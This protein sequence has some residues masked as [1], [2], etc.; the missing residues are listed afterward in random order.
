MSRG[1]LCCLAIVIS[2]LVVQSALG[3]SGG[4]GTSGDPYQ[5]ATKA[6][7]EQLA[8]TT[9]DYNKAFI[10]TAD[11]DLSGT[12]YTTAPIAPDM[13]DGTN[14][15]P[16]GYRFNG[17]F[18]GNGHRITGLTIAG[19]ARGCSCLGLIGAMDPYGTI[20]RLTIE[21][22]RI[23][24]SAYSGRV[25]ACVGWTHG[26][27]IEDCDSSGII[28]G[29]SSTGG[30]VGSF[31]SGTMKRCR[32][33]VNIDSSDGYTGGLVG[34]NY[35][36]TIAQCYAAGN[37]S[38]KMYVGGLIGANQAAVT[39]SYAL[40]AVTGVGEFS[41]AGGL[42]GLNT[43]AITRCYSTGSVTG[44]EAGGL[45][46]NISTTGSTTS[47]SF[48]DTQTS[49]LLTSPA[50]A[51]RTRL[52]MQDAGVFLAAGWDF[53]GESANGTND[54]WQMA[55]GDYPRLAAWPA[56]GETVDEPVFSVQGG[57]HPTAQNV[58]IICATPGAT[59]H[60]TTSGINPTES[61]AAISSGAT[62]LID[63][64]ITL[65]A[66]A[67]K[68]GMTA[69]GVATATYFIG[70]SY[71]GG[72]GTSADPYRISSKAD[73]LALAVMPA[74]YA[75]YFILTTD[76][77][78]TEEVFT[79]AV[80]AA[81]S[82]SSNGV[83]D[84][85]A[86]TGT[87]DGSGHAISNMVID[88]GES[89][90]DFLGL[91][92]SIGQTGKVMNLASENATIEAAASAN[93]GALVGLNKGTLQY[94]RSSGTING[95][96]CVGGLAG[97][98]N[99]GTMTRC[100]SS[101]AVSAAGSIAGGLIGS[102]D[103]PGTIV[104]SWATGNV[105][106]SSIAGGLAG[107]DTG[108]LGRCYATGSVNA[109]LYA[110]GLI[111]SLSGICKNCYATGSVTG[112]D[113]L[114]GL[115]GFI[116][117]CTLGMC[118]S[119]GRV[120]TASHCGGM[121]GGV[122]GTIT[123]SS[124]L[125]WDTQTSGRSSDWFGGG[126]TTAQM[127]T[128]STF[129]SAY[130]DFVGETTNGSNDYWYMPAG[131]YPM[132]AFQGIVATPVLT[133][134]TGTYNNRMN[135]TVTCDTTG[136][137]IHYTISGIDPTEADPVITSGTNILVERNL[138]IKVRAWNGSM[139]PS[140]V[141]TGTYTIVAGNSYSGG[142]GISVDP[143]VIAGKAD[144]LALAAAPGDY[145]RC[146]IMTADIDLAG[147]TYSTALIAPDTAPGT[148]DYQGTAFTGT[149]NGN[150]HSITALTVNDGG[151]GNDFLGLFGQVGT[152]G[153]VKSLAMVN[154][155]I[156]GSSGSG[157][158]GACAASTNS[159]SLEDCSSTGTISGGTRV[160]GLVGRNS[161]GTLTRCW[162]TANASAL[163]DYA[164]GLAAVNATGS[165]VSQCYATGNVSTPNCAGGLAGYNG[166]TIGN[167][168][169]TGTV[170]GTGYTGGLV[171]SSPG[172][173]AR[174][175][176][177]GYVTGT[178]NVGGLVGSGASTTNSF[179]D[180]QTSGKSTSSGGTG[181]TTAQM[182]TITVFIA[183]GWDFAGET[184]NGS[185]DYW[186]MQT[187][188]YPLLS[189]NIAVSD[190]VAAPVSS[191]NGGT[192]DTQQT[193]AIFCATA[194][195]AIHYTTN[196][197]DPVESDP[198]I[199]SGASVLVDHSMTL[200]A[201]AWKAGLLPSSVMT[202][203]YGIRVAIPSFNPAGGTY[204]TEQN[205][206]ISCTATDVTIHYTT[207]GLEPTESDPIVASGSSV[208]VDHGLTLKARAWKTDFAASSVKSG[209][210]VLV[211]S[212][213]VLSVPAG[214]YNTPQDVAV[215][216][217]AAGAVI[218]YTIDGN[219][220]NET[221]PIIASGDSLAIGQ[222][223]V[224]KVRAWKPGFV[225]SDIV[226]ARYNFYSGGAGVPADPFRIA[227]K[228]DLLTLAAMTGDYGK[229]FIMTSDIDL[230]GNVFA[231]AVIAPD[232]GGGTN[233]FVGTQW[234]GTFDGNGHTIS[235]L[236]ITG[237][238]STH[239]FLGLFGC[240]NSA[241]II[242][243]LVLE[244]VSISSTITGSLCGALVGENAGSI[245]NCHSGGTI[246]GYMV[247][248]GLVGSNNFGS[249]TRCYSTVAVSATGVLIGGLVGT[250]YGNISLSYATG[251]VSGSV[252]VGGL[253][254]GNGLGGVISDCYAT[255]NV[256]ATDT[257]AG[258]LI[259]VQEDGTVTRCYSAGHVTATSFAGGMIGNRTGA[260]I[261]GCFWDVQTS[262]QS[263]SPGGTGKTTLLMKTLSTYTAAGWD[264]A[265]ETANG[266]NDYWLMPVGSYPV[267]KLDPFAAAFTVV[268]ERRIGRT[269]FEYD[270]RVT[271]TN[272]GSESLN[273]SGFELT[274]VPA[275]VTIIDAST[276]GFGTI[277][278]GGSAAS[279]DT[280]T[281]RVD[282]SQLINSSQ[283]AWQITYEAAAGVQMMAT[284]NS[285][286]EL[287][288][289]VQGDVNADG[290]VDSADLTSLADQW[291]S[292][293]SS[294]G[295]VNFADFAALAANWPQEA[296]Q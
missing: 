14:L 161:S 97:K 285:L 228:T 263:T 290:I 241:S 78:L 278:A 111:G 142:R 202:T 84:G 168:Y 226:S 203:A 231:D 233:Y 128:Q 15:E 9:G 232:T 122:S 26:G 79:T 237:N 166:G 255:G 95:Q 284:G 162:S 57:T 71:G 151:T 190:T 192:Y 223:L 134:G 245:R 13:G 210:Y 174:T 235:N 173:I 47:A 214:T 24:G 154:C 254:G 159:G 247:V 20:K 145:G 86:F 144:L 117:N 37:V 56:A 99:L 113:Y 35:G 169:A 261:T 40:G 29:G 253:A 205:V 101:A 124:S 102:C 172:S 46:G 140:V 12:T 38:G 179:W 273:V 195:A 221:D 177:T 126:K 87:F 98:S 63:G 54:Y 93:C 69:S 51:G 109:G 268:A 116:S 234:S 138:T 257:M 266:T 32:S 152:G 158:M 68:D 83:F 106:A 7:L 182:Q 239:D 293:K 185:N 276:S 277:A 28:R 27:T 170:T 271:L 171:G 198:V 217:A 175:Y 242:R 264:F 251:P 197:L 112:G 236:T 218:H 259:G 207:S 252:E 199:A 44:Y 91:F 275:N 108:T 103:A 8:A 42:A 157:F 22:C 59:I 130:W 274:A 75:K 90:N 212:N 135:V 224:L 6:D 193:V 70:A 2:C 50:G 118:Y 147:T 220:P 280:V 167:S 208:L 282:R 120:T 180:T 16:M 33:T 100:S 133:P 289:P 146:F 256:T 53:V 121:V 127:K 225:P 66:K 227:T 5:I 292:A 270:C 81:D 163:V 143:Y 23:N 156:I 119:T 260:T 139:A 41:I 200:K 250:G 191:L 211:V 80:I 3:Y 62:V 10:L 189:F 291:L 149:F 132:L 258:G 184:A 269:T 165:T 48:W 31:S 178:S 94:C 30:I 286:L 1:R 114:G 61:D 136:A 129:T 240:T 64:N 229:C 49:G 39:D 19:D 249:I 107:S 55:G 25:G 21:N 150:G 131:Y 204:N 74:D 52:E 294:G 77:D 72:S 279:T 18:D 4:T 246:N 215:T 176:S 115:W 209:T 272:N 92:G 238:T 188:A 248:G 148:S 89:G 76:I 194:G 267:L 73:L 281:L 288:A 219:D 216:C 34:G 265:G 160:G 67:W 181:K 153:K 137:T 196:G 287:D 43:A 125:F 296:A 183:A 141:S 96:S 222:T 201:R 110:G 82:N 105:T 206:I 85:T 295:I 17:V 11:I 262:G 283:V 65:K 60:Y 88:A 243:N 213:P 45:V 58:A 186:Q 155:S 230:A 244:N 36:S 187:G 123:S 104:E 164:G